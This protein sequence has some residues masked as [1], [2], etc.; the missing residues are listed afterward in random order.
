MLTAP[1]RQLIL[2]IGIVLGLGPRLVTGHN[3]WL[4]EVGAVLC[5]IGLALLLFS[6]SR[7]TAVKRRDRGR[8]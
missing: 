1:W 2:S 5:G 7:A 6:M 3:T 4:S 8:H